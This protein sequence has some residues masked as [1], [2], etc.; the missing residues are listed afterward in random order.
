MSLATWITNGAKKVGKLFE[1]RLPHGSSSTTTSTRKTRR[2]AHRD[3]D[4]Q[5]RFGYRTVSPNVRQTI[6]AAYDALADGNL[7]RNAW[8]HADNLSADEANNS[9][10]RIEA[11]R[12]SRYE[13]LEANSY[14]KG[15]IHTVAAD[16]IGRGPRL[17]MQLTGSLAKYNK[18]LEQAW[19]QWAKKTKFAKTLRTM[20]V[21]KIV[22]GEAFAMFTTSTHQRPGMATLYLRSFEA[23]RCQ[24]LVATVNGP[25]QVDGLVI[26]T[27]TGEVT[28]YKVYDQITPWMVG[29]PREI[30]A[31][32]VC[33]WF[34]ADR[35]GQHRGIPELITSLPLCVLLR[36]YT[37]AV[38]TAARTAAKHT[39]VMQTNSSDVS[40]DGEDITALSTTD[41]EYDM[42]TVLPKG[43]QLSQMRAEQP[44]ST[45]EMTRDC[46]LGE[47]V[48]P[49]QAPL[50]IVLGSS[51]KWN[52]ASTQADHISYSL[53]LLIEREECEN[54]VVEPTF[55]EWWRE[56]Q[57]MGLAPADVDADEA[58][59]AWFWDNRRDADPQTMAT[60]RETNIK[61]GCSNRADEL[62]LRGVDIDS[63]DEQA[64][65]A[66]GLT[67]DQYRRILSRAM[68]GADNVDSALATAS[69]NNVGMNGAQ[70]QGLVL[71]LQQVGARTIAPAAARAAA[72]AAFPSLTPEQLSAIFPIA[73][74]IPSASNPTTDS[75]TGASVAPSGDSAG[76][77]PAAPIGVYAE[78]GQRSFTNN[79]KRIQSTLN[80]FAAGKMTRLLAE[81]TLATINLPAEQIKALLDDAADGS[82]DT[83]EVA[84]AT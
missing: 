4:Y 55:A 45:Y 33:H 11:R 27:D 6:E 40:E 2:Q 47:I 71:I 61:N 46:I 83:P 42:L 24:S 57:L 32:Q 43:Y 3:G 8:V 52:Y 29:S 56:M 68:W 67:V 60:A 53:K 48:R 21:A 73:E 25:D 18:P 80:E 5:P 15:A 38:V 41:I 81:T 37:L 13:C 31:D 36:E 84:N 78:I 22:D 70:I 16:M 64:A 69:T 39:A 12:R 20:A 74:P 65:T 58:T 10:V 62:A 30:P 63:H 44:T 9:G 75:A 66:A 7:L 49:L 59:H 77:T 17:Q 82:V 23:D 72:A 14:L 79:I 28:H 35:P 76:T 54:E 19:R 1:R 26:D 34:R 51:Q 50:N